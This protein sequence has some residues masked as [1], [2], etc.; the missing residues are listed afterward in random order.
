M[1]ENEP[2]RRHRRMSNAQVIALNLALKSRLTQL[3]DGTAFYAE[4]GDNDERVAVDLDVSVHSVTNMRKEM[5]GPFPTKVAE[6]SPE[7]F[8]ALR[9]KVDEHDGD[10]ANLKHR[11]GA[12]EERFR[13]SAECP[14]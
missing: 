1:S 7:G 8:A 2:A 14:I 4:P 11:L 13:L 3:G 9:H 12:L 6:V 10:I 5:F